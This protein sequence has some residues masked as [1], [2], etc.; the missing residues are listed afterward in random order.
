F[1]VNVTPDN[2]LDQ[3]ATEFGN[4]SLILKALLYQS[5]DYGLTLSAGMGVLI[6]TGED[7]RTTVIDYGSTEGNVQNS[8]Q[9]RRDISIANETWSLSPYLAVLATPTERAFTQGFASIEFPLNKSHVTY[10]D[11]FTVGHFAADPTAIAV[12]NLAPAFVA[13]GSVAEQTLLHLD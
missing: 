12:G 7:S 2:T 4:M 13:K 8:G 11:Q 6:P 10:I 1:N 5:Q 3:Y 9:R